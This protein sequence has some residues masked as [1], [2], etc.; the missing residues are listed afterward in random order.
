MPRK[1]T[2]ALMIQTS[3]ADFLLNSKNEFKQPA[4]FR[5]VRTR[6]NDD[7]RLPG[8]RGREAG[9]GRRGWS[10]RRGEEAEERRPVRERDHRGISGS[11]PRGV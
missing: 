5:V 6:E 8:E 9:G 4:Q 2:E 7:S 10:W 3:E 1:K 11:G